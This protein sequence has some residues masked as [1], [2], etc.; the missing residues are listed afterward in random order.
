MKKEPISKRQHYVNQAY[1]KNFRI[2]STEDS[3]FM[4]DKEKM[5]IAR[6]KTANVA[7][8][9][10]F[11]DRTEERIIEKTLAEFEGKC[12]VILKKVIEKE[13]LD[14][15]ISEEKE[16]LATFLAVQFLRSKE[17]RIDY[18]QIAEAVLER[19]AEKIVPDFKKGDIK[20]VE[21]SLSGL[22]VHTIF[23]ESGHFA[24]LF[25][26]KSWKLCI[27]NSS[28]PFWT[29][30]NPCAIHNDLEPEPFKSNLGIECK[31]FQLHF[32]L[33]SRLLLIIIDKNIKVIDLSNAKEIKYP[34]K[35]SFYRNIDKKLDVPLFTLMP[36]KEFVGG[37][38]VTF[39]NN[40][41]VISATR[42]IFSSNEDFSLADKYLKEQP[43]HR[44]ANRGRF[45]VM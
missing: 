31:G 16:L 5:S 38:R 39:E 32:P 25:L 15:L 26:D 24:K 40:L 2:E 14:Q 19:V 11:Y 35:R 9:N 33:S 8:E 45:K 37:D 23:K 18:K 43:I 42:F 28:I 29:S 34:K 44:N 20:V 1:L 30:D 21:D 13:D 7:S 41:Q 36:P 12:N 3:L 17:L 27:N 6:V 22:H 4:Y 10:F